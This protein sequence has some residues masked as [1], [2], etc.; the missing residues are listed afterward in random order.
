MTITNIEDRP[1]K[2]KKV[3]IKQKKYKQEIVEMENDTIEKIKKVVDDKIETKELI[4]KTCKKR[5]RVTTHHECRCGSIFCAKHRFAD[6]HACNFDYRKDAA[7]KLKRDNP[8]VQKEKM[9]K[10]S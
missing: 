5:L 7:E 1:M 8:V 4:C 2:R 10:G 9:T 6:Q 3:Q